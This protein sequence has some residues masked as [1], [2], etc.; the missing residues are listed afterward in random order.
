MTPFPCHVVTNAPIMTPGTVLS[1]SVVPTA[2]K[3]FNIYQQLML[4]RFL[5]GFGVGGEYPLSSTITAE[6]SSMQERDKHVRH[7]L[8]S[9]SPGRKAHAPYILGEMQ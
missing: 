8:P 1:A 2:A 6:A 5:L 4:W 7:I 3:G 9:S